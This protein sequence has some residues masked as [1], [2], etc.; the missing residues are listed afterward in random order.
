MR[1]DAAGE[2]EPP[3]KRDNGLGRALLAERPGRERLAGPDGG[4]PAVLEPDRPVFLD[5]ARRIA[6]LRSEQ[7]R[8]AAA[9]A[10]S[11]SP[12]TTP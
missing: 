3:G 10:Q 2:E 9:L 11:G 6:A 12:T 7:R 5:D 4:D 8:S 1:V